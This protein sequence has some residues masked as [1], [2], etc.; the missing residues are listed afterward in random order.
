MIPRDF[1][2]AQIV[3]F[4]DKGLV[5]KSVE[6]KQKGAGS[7]TVFADDLSDGIYAYNLIIDGA[8]VESKKMI[9]E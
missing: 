9:K 8:T 2:R 6:I 1:T 3:F 5:I 7:M 4:S